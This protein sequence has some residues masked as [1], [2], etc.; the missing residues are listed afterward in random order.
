MTTQKTNQPKSQKSD[1]VKFLDI[2]KEDLSDLVS[3]HWNDPEADKFHFTEDLFS[4]VA[5]R[6]KDSFKNGIEA[7]SRQASQGGQPRQKGQHSQ[8]GKSSYRSVE[9]PREERKYR[10]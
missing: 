5:Q 7:G 9:N 2:L 3:K 4:L 8:Y 10:N 1:T 6:V